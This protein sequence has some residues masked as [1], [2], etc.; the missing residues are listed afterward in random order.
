MDFLKLR[1]LD[2]IDIFLVAN[3]LY[4]IYKLVR[5]T[6]AI[7][8]FIGIV[9]VYGAWQLTEAFDM[10]MV[11]TILG[12]F[13]GVGM[14][15]LIVVFQQEIRNF[16]LMLGSSNF[17]LSQGVLSQFK[18]FKDTANESATN[19]PVLVK[20][21][22][23]LGSTKTGALIVIK[24]NVPLDF[25]RSSGDSMYT[26]V[27]AP[28]IESI[29]YKNSPLHDGA[30]LIEGGVI[31]ATRVTL[32][33]STDLDIPM[34]YGLRHRA[35]ISITQRTDSVALVVSE[36]TGGISYIKSGN[37]FR[38]DNREVLIKEITEDLSQY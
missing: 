24:R 28:I 35:A 29:F 12:Q 30:M 6:A 18:L 3:L 14:F 4:Y 37:F 9:I 11:S 21:C 33:V 15:A 8:I 19:V 20:V 10:M 23:S 32:P 13:I 25:I 34:H 31:T 22:E 2:I 7:N 27:N 5:G 26:K 36:E 38:Y 17:S 16:L 1:F